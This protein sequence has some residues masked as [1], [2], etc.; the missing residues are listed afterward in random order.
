MNDSYGREIDYM[1]ISI[2]D[3]CNLRCS[4]CMPEDMSFVP[5]AEQMNPEELCEITAA[6]AELGIRHIKLTGGEPLLRRDCPELIRRIKAIRG[7][8][9]VTLTTNGVLLE[10]FLPKLIDCGLDA[11]NISLNTRNPERY[12][13]I[14]GRDT[15]E[16][17]LRGI[18]K[19]ADSRIPVKIN[20]VT[21]EEN[22]GDWIDLVQ[23][24][25]E[26]PVDVRLIEVMPIGS[27]QQT[28][29]AGH[30]ILLEQLQNLWPDMEKDDAPHGFGP[31]VYF[32]IPGF[33][34]SVGMISAV[35]G[36]FCKSCNRLRLTSQGFLKPCLCYEEGAD[37]R[38]I[39]RE[40]LPEQ[41]RHE[42]LRKIMRDTI[43]LKPKEHCF[44]APGK[45]TETRMMNQI[46][47]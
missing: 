25:K 43:L 44:E 45:I 13:E 2:T 35:H 15:L 31:A 47:G 41:V 19:A 23:M 33:Q 36:K 20:V 8:Q 42:K 30:D 14:T 34:G 38:K 46:G 24:A 7:I 37:L 1:R 10:Q 32:K 40:S 16:P 21:L 12:R 5:E 18:Q 27:G 26:Y 9:N 28:A 3:R 17:V 4:Y 29:A 11:V 39:L 6:A 22:A